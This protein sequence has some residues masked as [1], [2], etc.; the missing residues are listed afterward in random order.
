[1]SGATGGVQYIDK[2]IITPDTIPEFMERIAALKQEAD[3]SDGW[4]KLLDK[5]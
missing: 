1:M 4:I 3:A 5:P 2:G